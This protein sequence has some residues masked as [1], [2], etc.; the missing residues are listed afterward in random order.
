MTT[1][2]TIKQVA[3]AG[4]VCV[5]I[6]IVGH[7][8]YSN[9][10]L[11]VSATPI[12]YMSATPIPCAISQSGS[13][14][15]V[16]D[17]LQTFTQR[18]DAV[19]SDPEN[20]EEGE[21]RPSP[22]ALADIKRILNEAYGPYDSDIPH[23]DIAPYFGEISITWR[24]ES[25]MLRLTAFSDHRE[26]RIDFGTTPEGSLGSYDEITVVT[27]EHLTDQ[28]NWLLAKRAVA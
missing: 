23:G 21:P 7:R 22:K 26:P 17:E 13:S 15:S 2:A 19:C 28:M 20:F 5:S 18:V 8:N 12:H 11:S 16:I 1:T 27:G 10:L 14:T 3:V 25:R 4:T 6:A 9:D 24:N